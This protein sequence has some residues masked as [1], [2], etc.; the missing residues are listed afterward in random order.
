VFADLPVESARQECIAQRRRGCTVDYLLGR[1]V[2]SAGLQGCI[3]VAE[4]EGSEDPGAISLNRTADRAPVC[5]RSKGGVGK[6]R[7]KVAGRA[8][9]LRL[10]SKRKAEPWKLF[11]PLLVTMFTMLLPERPTSAVKGPVAI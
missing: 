8:W 7:S 9:R 1:K 3:L 11:V 5:S 2:A 10:R 6:L 4:L